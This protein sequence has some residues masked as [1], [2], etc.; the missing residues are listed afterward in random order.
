VSEIERFT[1]QKRRAWDE[2]AGPRR[3][4]GMLPSF[5]ASGGSTLQP[6]ELQAAGDLA[7]LRRLALT[8]EYFGRWVPRTSSRLGISCRV[9]TSETNH[10]F[11]WPLGDVVSAAAGA[12]LEVRSL[13]EF[14]TGGGAEHASA[15]VR[16]VLD[17]LPR[18]YVLTAAKRG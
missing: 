15:V 7:G 14:A 8:G 11:C 6:E 2:V 1:E 10:Q 16:A 12:G 13:T 17:R 9:D 4:E 3:V 18:W 5:F